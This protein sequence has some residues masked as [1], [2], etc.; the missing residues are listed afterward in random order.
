MKRIVVLITLILALILCITSCD[1]LK[2][3]DP[4]PEHTHEFGEWFITE[5]AACGKSG[6]KVRHCSCGEKQSEAIPSLSHNVVIDEAVASTCT[7]TGL[8]E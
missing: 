5:N 2:P 8:T 6:V 7:T 4:S 3:S 1:L